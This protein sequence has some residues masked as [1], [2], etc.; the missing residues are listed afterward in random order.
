MCMSYY[1]VNLDANF[2]MSR[3]LQRSASIQPRTVHL[4]C[5]ALG[6]PVLPSLSLGARGGRRAL[7]RVV[8]RLA[9]KNGSE[10]LPVAD[11]PAPSYLARCT[12]D[13][14]YAWIMLCAKTN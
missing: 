3:S 14:K 4:K 13:I 11:L 10:A 8:A 2:P 5:L 1:F 9:R 12:N 7:R 6:P